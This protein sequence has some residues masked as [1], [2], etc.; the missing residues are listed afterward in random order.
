MK[1]ALMVSSLIIAIPDIAKILM[2]AFTFVYAVLL[3]VIG[4]SSLSTDNAFVCRKTV[5]HQGLY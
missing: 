2:L 3:P 4:K 1:A 5:P